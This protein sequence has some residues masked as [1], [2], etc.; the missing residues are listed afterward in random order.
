MRDR[1]ITAEHLVRSAD[2]LAPCF[3]REIG[4]HA[5]EQSIEPAKKPYLFPKARAHTFD[6]DR[7]TVRIDVDNFPSGMSKPLYLVRYRDAWIRHWSIENVE[8]AALAENRLAKRPRGDGITDVHHFFIQQ[9]RH[10]S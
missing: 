7:K 3:G 1:L 2:R 8:F 6:R 4:V 10:R 9:T 5:D